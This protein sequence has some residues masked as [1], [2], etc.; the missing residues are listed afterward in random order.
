MAQHEESKNQPGEEV[1]CACVCVEQVLPSVRFLSL[2]EGR[3]TSV[4]GRKS[5]VE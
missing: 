1:T 2:N 5:T 4:Q 3:K